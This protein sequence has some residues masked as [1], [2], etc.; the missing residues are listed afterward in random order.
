MFKKIREYIAKKRIPKNT[1]YCHDNKMKSCPYWKKLKYRDCC[2]KRLYYCK[3]LKMADTYQ[4][5]TLLWDQCK[6]CGINDEY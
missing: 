5:N 6:E 3:Y 2:G 1:C 4:G